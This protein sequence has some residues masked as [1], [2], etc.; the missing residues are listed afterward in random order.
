VDV[1][2]ADAAVRDFD[3]DV[4]GGKG[5]GGEGGPGEVSLGRGGVVAEPAVELGR[6]RHC[7]GSR[8]VCEI[9]VGNW[10]QRA[11]RRSGTTCCVLD[12]VDREASAAFC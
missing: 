11:W 8:L 5:L 2:A 7:S 4:N 12:G 3:V 10:E 9:E 1:G 6:R